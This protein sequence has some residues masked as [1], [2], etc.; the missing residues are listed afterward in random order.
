[1]NLRC[2]LSCCVR[3]SC[4]WWIQKIYSRKDILSITFVVK[5][6]RRCLNEVCI[7]QSL[8]KRQTWVILCPCSCILSPTTWY[9]LWLHGLLNIVKAILSSFALT[10]FRPHK[11][12]ILHWHT[13][14]YY[15]VMLAISHWGYEKQTWFAVEREKTE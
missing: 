8:C 14:V 7:V 3:N 9:R 12:I 13:L 2:I 15:H 10:P 11:H 4:M 6:V 5:C 1:M